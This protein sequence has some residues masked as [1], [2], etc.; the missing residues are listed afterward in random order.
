MFIVKIIK[1]FF[2][3]I[4]VYLFFII[5]KIIGLNL[6]RKFFSFLFNTIGPHIKSQQTINN[7]LEKFLGIQN[8]D[9]KNNIKHKMWNNYGKTFVEY[10]YL[11]KFRDNNNH[12]DIKGEEILNKIQQ[13]NKPVIFVSGHFA[14][15]ELMSMELTKRN[16]KLATIYR[17]LNNFFL[18]FF[19]EY[20]RKKYICQN[21]IKKGLVGVKDSIHFI[22]NNFSIALMIDQRVSEG[23]KLPFFEHM[24][25]TTT[26]PAQMALK[27]N[28]DIVPIYISRKSNDNFEI[29]IYE[30]IKVS[31]N[32][33]TEA[34]KINISIKLNKILEEMIL[35]DPG[36]WIWTHNRWK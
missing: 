35:K 18:N 34:N 36:Q 11:K 25:F 26:M 16:H 22:K 28:L 7:N 23:K 4:F 20:L 8:D 15:F 5:I 3:A 14:N 1:Y 24:A 29:E 9:I 2:Q 32:D 27:F 10:L 19:M 21:Q 13:S 17:P 33:E 30:P 31:K 6:S 12:I